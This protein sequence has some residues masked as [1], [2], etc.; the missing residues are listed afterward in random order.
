MGRT[1]LQNT[2]YHLS[3]TAK[4]VHTNFA[5]KKCAERSLSDKIDTIQKNQDMTKKSGQIK[6]AGKSGQVGPLNSTQLI[7]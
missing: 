7:D 5:L 4:K 3:G 6:K 2:L 1:E